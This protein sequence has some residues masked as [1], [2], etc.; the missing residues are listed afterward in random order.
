M[1]RQ[2]DIPSSSYWSPPTP[3]WTYDVFLSFR[4]EDTHRNFTDHLYT[5]LNQKG[6]FAFRD[7]EQLER[8]KPS[9]QNS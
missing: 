6:V 3:Q 7:A 2:T 8:E 1:I 9:R 5:S 4:S